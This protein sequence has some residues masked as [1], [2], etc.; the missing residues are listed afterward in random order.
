MMYV[1]ALMDDQHVVIY[2]GHGNYNRVYSYMLPCGQK[3][4]RNIHNYD[5]HLKLGFITTVD[6]RKEAIELEKQLIAKYNPRFNK[7]R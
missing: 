7:A 6:S 5:G 4:F 1:Y 2:A 3:V